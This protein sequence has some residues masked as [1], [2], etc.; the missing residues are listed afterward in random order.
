V[1]DRF[2]AHVIWD[3]AGELRGVAPMM[4]TEQPSFGP[5]RTRRLQFW[6]TDANVT[7]IRGVICRP[8]DE[9]A[10]V[11]ALAAAL[12]RQ[13]GRWDFMKWGGLRDADALAGERGVSITREFPDFYLQPGSDWE[14][15]KASLPRNVK[16]SLRKCYNAPK[17]DGHVLDFRVV[18]RESEVEGAL[19]VFFRLHAA[20][21]QAEDTITHADVFYSSHVQEFLNEYTRAMAANGH[22]RIFQLVIGGEVVATRIGYALGHHLYLYFSGFNPE[23]GK[24]S[25]MTTTV[26][27]AIKYAIGAGFTTVN[28]SPGNDVSKTRWRPMEIALRDATWVSPSWRGLATFRMFQA[29]EDARKDP[30]F[31]RYF[32]MLRRRV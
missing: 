6:G 7:E 10:V 16:E 9:K 11:A 20:R 1:R 24:Y 26:A 19:D 21:S 14:G 27:E 13:S 30:R 12:R 17:R 15:F 22:A 23:W 31:S 5:I 8:A 2:F 3:D 32:G 29:V 18:E 4:V 28:L 25:V